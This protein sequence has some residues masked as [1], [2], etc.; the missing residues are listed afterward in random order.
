MRPRVSTTASSE[1]LQ[2]VLEACARLPLD[3]DPVSLRN[4]VVET[5]R[6]VFQASLA[7]ILVRKAESYVLESRA[8]ERKNSTNKD[9]LASARNCA[10][11][12][13]H[14]QKLM[15]FRFSPNRSEAQDYHGLAQPLQNGSSATALLMARKAAFSPIEISAFQVLGNVSRLALDNVELAHTSGQSLGSEQH[16]KRAENLMEMAL[17]LGSAL[18]LPEFVSNFTSRVSGMMQAECAILALA[19]GNKLES[20][21]FFGV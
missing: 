18:R 21:G 12:A 9:L 14:Q 16:R 3:G 17:E 7:A 8:D 15:E 13:I 4:F 6:Q 5:A 10:I 1:C 2:E 11:Q 19:Q 20:V